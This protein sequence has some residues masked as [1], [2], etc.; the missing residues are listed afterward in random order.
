LTE[1]LAIDLKGATMDATAREFIDFWIENSIHAA[2]QDGDAG[3]TQDVDELVRRCVDMARA[4]GLTE[5][6]MQAEV[7]DIGAY[8]RDK[9]R[10]ANKSE[11]APRG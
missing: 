10:A 8:I 1:S 6:A 4:Q 9:L 2:E 11:H 7:G 3:A 5:A